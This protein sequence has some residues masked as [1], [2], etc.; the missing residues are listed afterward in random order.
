[1]VTRTLVAWCLDWPIVAADIAPDEPGAVL[2]ANRVVA[3]S[4]IARQLGVVRGLR[5]REAQYRCPELLISERDVATEV[6]RFEPI[7]SELDAFAPRVEILQ[8]GTALFA[9]P[10][11]SNY[12]GGDDELAR[13]VQQALNAAVEHRTQVSVGIA[14]GV[15]AARLAARTR[16]AAPLVIAEGDSASFLAPLPITL[17]DQ[18]ELTS[19]LWRLGVQTL[20]DFAQLT[21][22]D[23]VGRFGHSG[24]AAHGLAR[25]TDERLLEAT[26]PPEDLYATMDFDPAIERM[27]QAAFA[28]RQL[29]VSLHEQLAQR[30]SLIHISEPTRPY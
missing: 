28:A 16:G 25:G 11:P 24:I 5:R 17:L 15:F 20:G 8:P 10:G 6:R 23:V 3:S 2:H 22:A 29:A 4:E 12:F 13:L 9:T 7:A 21:A 1:M 26:E 19:V 18:P 30:L 14:D 27:D